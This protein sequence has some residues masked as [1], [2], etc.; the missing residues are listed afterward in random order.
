MAFV[1]NS[2]LFQGLERTHL[3]Q[4]Y[5]AG[6]ILVYGPNK[7]VFEE[8]AAGPDG[9]FYIDDVSVQEYPGEAY[10]G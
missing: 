6:R 9:T 10:S 8:G 7:V 2:I 5:Q 4:L 3:G 1:E